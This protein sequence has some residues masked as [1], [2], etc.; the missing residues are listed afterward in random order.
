MNVYKERSFSRAAEAVGLSQP[1]VSEHIKSL[2]RELRCRLFDRIGRT[3]IPTE[4][5]ER[6]YTGAVR[7]LDE[8]EA[9]KEEVLSSERQ[10]RGEIVLGA[11]TIPGAYLLPSVAAEFKAHHEGVSFEIVIEDTAK[12]T[13]MVRTHQ[14]LMGVV[15]AKLTP[16]DLNYEEVAEDEVI[17]VCR[18]EV[19]RDPAITDL[20]VEDLKTL[21]FIM[22][23]VGS[24][25]REAFE[26]YLQS[27]GINIDDLNT[28]ATLGSTDA[29][30]EAL[31][32]GL[33][34]GYISRVAVRDELTRGELKE[35][36]IEGFSIQRRFYLITHKKRSLPRV[37]REFRGFLL[38][39]VV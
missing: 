19:L 23:E 20:G 5:G 25:T 35:I 32:A 39:K 9:L 7:L 17:L 4:E 11:S 22:R 8:I 33:G 27:K 24:G 18:P 13:E 21:P 12:V 14:I 10:I 34:V 16:A 26:K 3:V 37:Y 31:K 29:V 6:L 1:T 2:E 36:R 28:V 38:R 30:R 15:G